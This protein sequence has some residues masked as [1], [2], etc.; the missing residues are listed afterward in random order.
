MNNLRQLLLK[1]L[2]DSSFKSLLLWLLLPSSL[3]VMIFT[4]WGSIANIDEHVN[5]AFDRSLAGA[6]YAISKNMHYESGGISM[7]QPFYL[8]EL[9]ELTTSSKVYFRVITTDGL[10]E[11]G[12][13]DIPLPKATLKYDIPVFEY[14]EYLGESV[15][16]ATMLVEIP[17]SAEYRA[18]SSLLIQLAETQEDRN[19]V[20]HKYMW[21]TILSNVIMLLLLFGFI[22]LAV[23]LTSSLIRTASKNIENRRLD[24]LRPLDEKLLPREM[25]P[26]TK[27]INSHID[28]YA[29]KAEQQRIFLDD[30]SHQLRTPLS[31]IHT[32]LEYA[33]SLTNN[34]ELKEV[35]SAAKNRLQKTVD[36]TNQFLSLARVQ[37]PSGLHG[38]AEEYELIELNALAEQV[39]S[40]NAISA[41]KKK[42]D[43]GFEAA[44]QSVYVRGIAWLIRE[45]LNNLIINAIRYCPKGAEITVTVI[46]SASEAVVQLVDNGPGMSEADLAGAGKRFRRGQE[47]KK[48]DGFGLG[49]SIVQSVM[50]THQGTFEIFNNADGAGLCVRLFFRK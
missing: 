15:R 31:V 6:L 24:D 47:G 35:L 27:A 40:E 7:E 12:Y 14:G 36:L 17:A 39:V 50:D 45:A 42:M 20:I 33:E 46:D 11:I 23:V 25:R 21:E 8:L 18:G 13:V 29:K 4:V 1:H 49:L 28:R 43:Y 19:Q 30:A 38:N 3:C 48:Q 5:K 16:V 34:S 22:Y 2:S 41:L 37:G 32:Q 9:L 44:P 10:T 26:L